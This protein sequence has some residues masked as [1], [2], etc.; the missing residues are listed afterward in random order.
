MIAFKSTGPSQATDEYPALETLKGFA[1][2]EGAD[3]A[4]AP[5]TLLKAATSAFSESTR[6][7]FV[8]CEGVGDEKCADK[9]LSVAAY[10]L[11]CTER[12]N[13]GC[14]IEVYAKSKSGEK[15][16]ASFQRS[17]AINPSTDFEQVIDN[18]IPA[19]K[20]MG[21]LWRFPNLNHGGNTDLYAVQVR[22]AG[23]NQ[24][25]LE[26]NTAVFD[27][28]QFQI[29]AVTQVLGPYS[30]PKVE[31]VAESLAYSGIDIECVMNERG[32][33]FKRTSLP[34]DFRFGM[35]VRLPN[36]I[37]GWFHG[38]ISKPEFSIRKSDEVLPGT[39]EY[40]I[41]A[42]PVKVPIVNKLIPYGQWSKEFSEYIG[43][44]WPMSNGGGIIL[45][46]N[47]GRLA[48][49]TTKRFLPMIDDKATSSG[50]F[51]L[52][53]TLNGWRDGKINEAVDSRTIECSLGATEVSGVVTTNSMVYSQGPPTFNQVTQTLDYRV[54]SPH[55]DETG[56]ENLGTYDLLLNSRV[57]RCIYGFGEAPL[58]AEI[59]VVSDD[60]TARIATTVL[61]E[62]GPWLFLSASGF[63][64]SEPVVRVKLSQQEPIPISS[65][66]PA[67]SPSPQTA[68]SPSV[69]SPKSSYVFPPKK[70]TITCT[71]GLK[72]RKIT[73][74]SPK[75]PKGFKRI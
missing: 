46:G 41:E 69:Q 42:E 59:E 68:V 43:Q 64:F 28:A 54:L 75:C 49:E 60:G 31:I 39:F 56:K 17:V 6:M 29:S 73:S 63:T 8:A 4:G 51:W 55:L 16:S 22:V 33:C 38:R 65:P 12:N 14:I 61:G 11:P 70:K 50:D 53:K 21:G 25:P 15:I 47:A 66:A 32:L 57:A 10:L 3:G 72:K 30:E 35:K 1:V 45:P 37:I 7:R 20:G 58:R 23:F 27:S 36:S 40:E 24:T 74:S 71:N 48:L 34:E 52:V 67:P 5:T 44:Q 62:R 13:L 18:R 26:S 9:S 2:L 19:G